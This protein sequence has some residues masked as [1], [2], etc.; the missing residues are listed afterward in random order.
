M[1]RKRYVL[2]SRAMIYSEEHVYFKGGE[3]VYDLPVNMK[4]VAGL[5]GRRD[6]KRYLG[7]HDLSRALIEFGIHSEIR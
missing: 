2:S 5:K 6:H 4:Y 1:G 3:K 7:H